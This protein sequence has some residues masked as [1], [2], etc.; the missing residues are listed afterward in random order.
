[1]P[2]QGASFTNHPGVADFKG[3]SYFFY[4]DGALPGGG[5]FTR[6]VS[7]EEFTYNA[8]GAFPTIN[9]TKQGPAGIG[10]LDPYART[11]AETMAWESGIKTATSSTTGVYVTDIDNGDFIKV[12]G[13]D[14]GQAGAGTF[15]ASVASGVAGGSIELHL[16]SVDG[17][18]IGSV[19]APYTGGWEQWRTL[20]ASVSGAAGIH[21]LYL[22]FKGDPAEHLFNFDYWQFGKRTAAHD[23]AALNATVDRYKIDT[24]AGS[25]AARLKVLAIYS[26]GT[27][28]DVTTQATTEASG[29]IATARDG[30]V[31]GTVFGPASINAAYAGKSDQTK[32]LVKDLKTEVTV[33]QL[34]VA[35]DGSRLLTGTKRPYAVTAEYQDDHT[36][37][38]TATATYTNTHP[39]V[40]TAEKGV[41]TARQAGKT[42]LAISFQGRLGAAATSQLDLVV[43][44]R[45][46]YA[47]TKAADFSEQSGTGTEDCSEG[48]KNVCN[49]ENGD[50]LRFNAV[51]FGSGAASFEAR[52]ASAGSGGDIQIILDNLTGP[53]IGTCAVEPNGGWQ[54]WVTRTCAVT[55]AQGRHDVYLKFTGK[56]GSLLNV[57]WWKFTRSAAQGK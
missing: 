33:K 28:T 2:T 48:Q 3:K 50:W 39:E 15:T 11:E 1:M 24:A 5:G 7:V 38:I 31:T 27:S 57:N 37:D 13:V 35:A 55:G 52:V 44:D 10:H 32:M 16:D 36:Q 6:S 9:M 45:D 21:D 40:A 8:D 25:N 14:F 41:I 54:K 23:L 34:K 49:I 22:V 4:H 46:P 42:T 17:T 12:K 47:Q 19:A 18:L 29:G 51:D 30:L 56:R 53:I 20:T 26:D 43:A